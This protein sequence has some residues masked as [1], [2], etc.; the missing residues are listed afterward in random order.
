MNDYVVEIKDLHRRFGNVHAVNGLNLSVK[1]GEIFGL[2]G[3]NG[4]GKT[5]TIKMIMG[6][7]E[8]NEGTIQVM[9]LNPGEDD[10]RIKELIGYVAEEPLIYKSLTPKEL[11]NFIASIRRLD[12]QKTTARL[13]EL[14]DSLEAVKYYNAVIQTLSHG[15][16][17]KIQ[18]IASMLHNPPLLIYDEPLIGLDARSARVVK[19]LLQIHVKHGGTVIL[20]THIMEVAQNM[21]DRIAIICDGKLSALGSLQDLRALANE[22]NGTL[23]NV[24]IKL[25]G[26]ELEIEKDLESLRKVFNDTV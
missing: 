1:K 3:P 11:F 26:Q 18:V 6:L 15:N 24:F 14:M 4:A 16:K 25:T 12:P 5:T 22:P 13:R 23:E 19:E 8:P 21:C 9:G 2:L 17:Q 20:C 7:L 10:V